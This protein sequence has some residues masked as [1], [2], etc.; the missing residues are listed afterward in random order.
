MGRTKSKKAA[1]RTKNRQDEGEATN[2]ED[3]IEARNR[4]DMS[5]F[6]SIGIIPRVDK[7]KN[8]LGYAVTADDL[9][10]WNALVKLNEKSS[11]CPTPSDRCM[12]ADKPKSRP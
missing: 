6:L 3:S 12:P 5:E 9:L 4:Q 8:L 10:K 11:V 1:A 7:V 2:K